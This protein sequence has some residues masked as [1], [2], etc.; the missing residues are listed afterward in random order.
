MATILFPTDF[1]EAATHAFIYALKLADKLNA[2]IVTVHAFERPDLNGVSYVPPSLEEF[3]ASIDLQ[4]FE[5][6]QTVIP[7]FRQIQEEQGLQSVPLS[8]TIIEGNTIQV[9]LEQAKVEEADF[10]V[11]GTT[12]ARGLKEILLGSVAGEIL[13]NATCPV[14]A[15]PAQ[16]VFDGQLNVIAFTT[17]FRPEEVE[18]LRKVQELFAVFAPT[19]HV[20]NVDLAHTADFTHR[21]EEFA[22]HF[23]PDAKLQF[24]TLEG[25]AIQPVLTQFFADE[26]VDLVAMV[27]QKRGFFQELFHYSKTKAMSYHS[28]TPVLSLPEVTLH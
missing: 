12:G 9:I 5:N 21:M 23:D 26:Q 1:S 24:H 4:E 19:I 2:R 20:V 13:E 18:G 25:T 14:L 11:M 6:Y 22:Q 10:I 17:S 3:Y 7:A 16:A 28:H 27:T 15:V 8:H